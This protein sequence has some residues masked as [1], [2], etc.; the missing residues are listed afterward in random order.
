MEFSGEQHWEYID[1]C[2][3]S[4]PMAE[5]IFR[6]NYLEEE[7]IMAQYKCVPAPKNLVIDARGSYDDAVRSFADLINNETADGWKYHS[8]NN[9][10]VTRKPGCLA[11]LFGQKDETT[12]F[13]M[14]V[15][16]KE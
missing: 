14:L 1:C 12:Y 9:I 11:A 10:A 8:M 2:D 4:I 5:L 6:N 7:K 13:N 3:A 16:V 15:F